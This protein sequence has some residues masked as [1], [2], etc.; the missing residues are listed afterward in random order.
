MNRYGLPAAFVLLII[1]NAVVLAGVRYNRSGEPD[2]VV[3]LTE[4]ELP[5]ASSGRENSATV[6]QLDW[7]RYDEDGAEWF[8]RRKLTESGFDCRTSP[9]APDAE[10]RY[11]KALPR[12]TFVVLEFEGPAWEAW[13]ARERKKLEAMEADIATGKAGRKESVKAGKRFAWEQVVG[14]RLFPVDVGNDPRLLR[15]RYPDRSRCIITPAVVR[16]RFR[17]AQ[18]EKG[19]PEKPAAV[20]GWI[21]EVL[22]DSIQAPRD[23]RGLL[24]KVKSGGKPWNSFY[25]DEEKEEKP[26]V[27]RYTVVLKYGKRHEPWVVEVRPYG[28]N[29]KREKQSGTAR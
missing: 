9:D 2:A 15:K 26:P 19:K 27:P 28:E 12:K 29:A 8:D 4:R 23:W 11:G 5:L 20:C 21:E 18:R 24:A 10:L 25:F 1:V 7:R 13:Q 22:T 3:E 14:S 16:L 6:L 17:A